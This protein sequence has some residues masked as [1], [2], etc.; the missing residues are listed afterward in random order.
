MSSDYIVYNII[1]ISEIKIRKLEKIE[2]CY[3]GQN[4]E[5]VID[6]CLILKDLYYL[7]FVKCLFK[8]I[9]NGE[10]YNVF[11]NEVLN[12]L[13]VIQFFIGYMI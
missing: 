12:Y 9:E 8:D 7:L 13:I 10:L 6:L 5:N 1:I 2:E 3:Y 4:V 11:R